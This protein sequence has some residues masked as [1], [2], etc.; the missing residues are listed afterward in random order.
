[1]DAR[2]I[3]DSADQRNGAD[4]LEIARFP[5]NQVEDVVVSRRRYNG[6][7]LIDARVHALF[8]G[9]TEKH[10][11]RKGICIKVAL[12]PDLIAALNAAEREARRLGLLPDASAEPKPKDRT[13]AERQRRRRDRLRDSQ[14]DKVV[15]DAPLFQQQEDH[16]PNS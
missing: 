13:A 9:A 7:D 5:K 1:M 3:H 8:R 6:H 11:T 2:N 4:T 14:R 10:P 12:L 16:H 15:T